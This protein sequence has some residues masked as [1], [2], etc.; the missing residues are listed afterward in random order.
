MKHRKRKWPEWS[1]DLIRGGFPESSLLAG[2]EAA[3][4]DAL[5]G[6][7]LRDFDDGKQIVVRKALDAID[8]GWVATNTTPFRIAIG[9][10]FDAARKQHQ[11]SEEENKKIE[12]SVGPN[13]KCIPSIHIHTQTLPDAED[14]ITGPIREGT[15]IQTNRSALWDH[16]ESYGAYV[17]RKA[18]P[19]STLRELP[20][21]NQDKQT[22]LSRS[23]GNGLAG[24]PP[25]LYR[26][27]SA[28]P[29]WHDE[30]EQNIGQLLSGSGAPGALSEADSALKR[31]SI[32]ILAGKHAENWA[33]HDN[34]DETPPVQA[35]LML[36]EPKK[37]FA[38]GEFY[39]ARQTRNSDE[40]IDI[41]RYRI[42]FESPGDLVIFMA[43]KNS[44]W[45]HG[46][47]PVHAGDEQKEE[48]EHLRQV[49]GMLQPPD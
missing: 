5:G 20:E 36:S 22:K 6:L 44:G 9:G 17:I 41:V 14:N 43:G 13:D 30:L 2:T 29:D 32:L 35:I 40:K 48:Q 11:E 23:M 8:L 1:Q 42:S 7:D 16:M 31:K 39:V 4:W 18:I 28:R 19:A 12:S 46:M 10:L 21:T 27:L 47:L 38:G 25:S 3:I 33:H 15:A 24:D 34:N 26:D 37:D 49:I 45:W